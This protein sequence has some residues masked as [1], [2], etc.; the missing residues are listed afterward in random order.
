MVERIRY[1]NKIRANKAFYKLVFANKILFKFGFHGY[2]SCEPIKYRL[3]PQKS[4]R[5]IPFFLND[6]SSSGNFVWRLRH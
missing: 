3:L 1:R 2:A 4:K 6:Y 5:S